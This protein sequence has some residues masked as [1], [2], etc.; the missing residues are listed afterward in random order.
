MKLLLDV[1][2]G[3]NKDQFAADHFKDH[4]WIGL[5][6]TD[7]SDLYKSDEF[8]LHDLRDP[9]PF[10]KN[11][12]DIVWCHHTLEHL[13]PMH[14]YVYIKPDEWQGPQDFLVYVLNEM[15]RVLKYGGEAHLIV[16][17]KEHTNAWRSP[18]H[19]R[20]FDENFFTSAAVRCRP[21]S[22]SQWGHYAKWACTTN[23]ILDDCH[24]YA[25]Y[26]ALQYESLEE[27]K[28][29]IGPLKLPDWVEFLGVRKDA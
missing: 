8:V 11:Y 19:Y 21:G 25:V 27:A 16:P 12:F 20:F 6:K 13:P 9:L 28:T 17:W 14:P 29:R 24:V 7:Y 26:K 1:G 3:D 18:T 5:D 4:K 15:W 23:V 2:C 22:Q 10:P